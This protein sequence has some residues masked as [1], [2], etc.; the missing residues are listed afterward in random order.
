MESTRSRNFGSKYD[1]SIVSFEKIRSFEIDLTTSSVLDV[2][3][4]VLCSLF[5]LSGKHNQAHIRHGLL[6]WAT[7]VFT[8]SSLSLIGDSIGN[9][10]VYFVC[11]FEKRAHL[12]YCRLEACCTVP[13]K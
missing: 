1:E 12:A 11:Y 10:D 6:I 5:R 3:C 13:N 2:V 7:E 4:L 9:K 8:S